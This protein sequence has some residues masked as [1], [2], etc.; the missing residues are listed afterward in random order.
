MVTFNYNLLNSAI[1]G[2]GMDKST[3]AKMLEVH[4]NTIVAWTNPPTPAAKI[5][6]MPDPAKLAKLLAV[7]GW[8]AGRIDFNEFYKLEAC[9]EVAPD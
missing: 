3:V 4:P 2:T 7:L 1:A 6:R 8:R 5:T 9:R